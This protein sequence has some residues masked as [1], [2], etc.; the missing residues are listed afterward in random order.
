MECGEKIPID[1]DSLRLWIYIGCT[2][3]FFCLISLPILT[4]YSDEEIQRH[5][6]RWLKFGIWH[7]IR[8]PLRF[9]VGVVGIK[10]SL[11]EQAAIHM[12]WRAKEAQRG[13]CFPNLSSTHKPGLDKLLLENLCFGSRKFSIIKNFFKKPKNMIRGAEQHLA[14]WW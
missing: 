14:L 11:V 7:G 5:W 6:N 2:L 9:K 12:L 13:H 10:V 8:C 4:F 1:P 3:L